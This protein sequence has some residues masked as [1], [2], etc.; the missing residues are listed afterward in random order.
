MMSVQCEA[1]N[2]LRYRTSHPISCW[3][4]VFRAQLNKSHETEQ[5]LVLGHWCHTWLHK[6]S[7]V[8]SLQSPTHHCL[9]AL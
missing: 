3:H 2:D 8:K 4:P 5:T 6:M 1:V 9:P 7:H